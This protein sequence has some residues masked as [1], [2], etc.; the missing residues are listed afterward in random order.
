MAYKVRDLIVTVIP[1]DALRRIGDCEQTSGGCD[2]T[3]GGCGGGTCDGGSQSTV[4]SCTSECGGRGFEAC[5]FSDEVLDPLNRLID[6][7]YMI[8][9]RMLLRHAVAR[10]RGEDLVAID[11]ELAPGSRE[12]IEQLE[13]RLTEAL[14]D[15]RALK[16]G[17]GKA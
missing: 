14:A 4:G 8:E 9:L 7:A 11:A 5:G 12:D 17:L 1:S 13:G 16:G 10:S 6:P 15:V 3:S 2:A